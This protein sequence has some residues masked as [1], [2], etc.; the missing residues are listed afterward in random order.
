MEA[1]AMIRAPLPATGIVLALALCT[2]LTAC[3]DAEWIGVVYPN[4]DNLAD[5]ERLGV[6]PDLASCQA[7]ASAA[8]EA[9]VPVG[10]GGPIPGWECATEC[11]EDEA[12]DLLCLRVEAG[13]PVTAANP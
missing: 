7:S 6:F 10:A 5:S 3:G 8:A 1:A 13:A 11:T 9:R 2:A 4:R 12:G